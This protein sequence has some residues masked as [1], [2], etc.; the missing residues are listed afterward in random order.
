[1]AMACQQ[2]SG[3]GLVGMLEYHQNRWLQTVVNGMGN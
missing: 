3:C 1:M 2:D